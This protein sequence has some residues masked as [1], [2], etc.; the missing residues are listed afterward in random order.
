MDTASADV[1]L[2]S[3]RYKDHIEYLN[4]QDLVGL[5]DG[6]LR[7]RL[8]TYQY[9]DQPD[10]HLGFIVEDQPNAS[11]AV[12]ASGDR[13]DLYGYISMTVAA[14]QMQQKEIDELKTELR[15]ARQGCGH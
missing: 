4:A 13:V 1:V 11:P 14:L 5:R 7:T 2:L 3:R 15:R 9:R 12:A 8:A 10:R 6:L